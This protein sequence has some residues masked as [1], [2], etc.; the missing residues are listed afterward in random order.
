VS[1]RLRANPPRRVSPGKLK[2]WTPEQLD[3]LSQVS[4]ADIEAAQQ[5]VN[6]AAPTAA[7]LLDAT[8]QEDDV[9]ES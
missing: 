9:E 1:R 2:P 8:I 3:A 5:L 4:P 6:R 7:K